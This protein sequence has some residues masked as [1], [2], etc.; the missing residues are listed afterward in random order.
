MTRILHSCVVWE[1]KQRWRG[2]PPRGWRGRGVQWNGVGD[3]PDKL[4]ITKLPNFSCIFGGLDALDEMTNLESWFFEP[5]RLPMKGMGN[6]FPARQNIPPGSWPKFGSSA[7]SHED[8]GH[9][10]F[11]FLPG[12]HRTMSMVKNEKRP[13]L[14]HFSRFGYHRRTVGVAALTKIQSVTSQTALTN[15]VLSSHGSSA[16]RVSRIMLKKTFFLLQ[17][18]TW[19][20]WPD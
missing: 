13:S 17:E 14:L 8:I 3:V 11:L 1:C 2:F 19:K 10:A 5:S 7:K 16:E 12:R 9:A 6:G 18:G 20:C 4:Y 15:S